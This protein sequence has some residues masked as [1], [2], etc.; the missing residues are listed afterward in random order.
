MEQADRLAHETLALG[1][2]F[3]S[4]N[5]FGA[6]S[7][8]LFAVRREQGRVAELDAPLQAMV[9]EQPDLPTFR[10]A[11]AAIA[12]ECGRCEEARDAVRQLV[13][14]DFDRFPRDRNWIVALTLVV[15]GA[16]I[17]GDPALTQRVYELLSPYAGRTVAVGHGAACDGAVDHHLGVLAAALG[18]PDLADEHFTAARALHRQLRAP[19]WLA[20]T[21]R[22]HAR[23]L[24]KRGTP[25]DREQARG[26]QAEAI[27]AYERM[28]LAHRVRQAR[29]IGGG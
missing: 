20:H 7:A 11:L 10:T 23:A 22:E 24:W 1:Q 6:Y 25:G 17:S 21:Q 27:A 9:R 13:E 29:E 12:G 5:A 3:G 2:G 14:G 26:L 8:Q 18:D 19:L 15:P 28:G 16:A 4:P